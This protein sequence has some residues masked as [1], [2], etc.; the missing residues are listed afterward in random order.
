MLTA[1]RGGRTTPLAR[2]V[3]SWR[4]PWHPWHRVV[5]IDASGQALAEVEKALSRIAFGSAIRAAM[6]VSST[7][8]GSWVMSPDNWLKGATALQAADAGTVVGFAATAG[9]VAVAAAPVVSPLV[10][11]GSV[12]L[13]LAAAA[14]WNALVRRTSSLMDSVMVS[15]GI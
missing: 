3:A 10:S 15:V 14:L 7:T 12:A 6:Q 4:S 13:L 9:K 5:Y 8:V 1:T 11:M 2:R